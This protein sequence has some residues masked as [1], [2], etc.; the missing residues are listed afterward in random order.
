MRPSVSALSVAADT[1]VEVE[2]TDPAEDPGCSFTSSRTSLTVRGDPPNGF[3]A[4]ILWT[5][6]CSLKNQQR[7]FFSESSQVFQEI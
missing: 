5:C 4:K 1:G 3:V 6:N 7:L 2:P